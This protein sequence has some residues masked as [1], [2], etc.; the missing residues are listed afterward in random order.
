M[1]GSTRLQQPSSPV[2]QGDEI[3]GRC[4]PRAIPR[5]FASCAEL[6]RSRLTGSLLCPRECRLVRADRFGKLVFNLLG[7]CHR[8]S[9]HAIKYKVDLRTSSMAVLDTPMSA[10]SR[11]SSSRSGLYGHRRSHPSAIPDSHANGIFQDHL[12]SG[13]EG[14]AA[15]VLVDLPT[16]LPQ[17]MFHLR[18]GAKQRLAA[19]AHRAVVKGPRDFCIMT[20]LVLKR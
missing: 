14:E 7:P 1:Q 16:V 6:G 13:N 18:N 17:D 3:L 5:H 10:S 9:R 2:L 8:L 20:T 19:G 4:C 11:S 12:R 15:R